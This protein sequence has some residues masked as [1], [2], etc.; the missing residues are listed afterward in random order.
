M[1]KEILTPKQVELLSIVKL[2][3]KDFGLVGGT[4]VAL[5]LGHRR[6]IDLD[7]FSFRGFNN[8]SIKQ[9]IS[10]KGKIDEVKSIKN[11]RIIVVDVVSVDKLSDDQKIVLNPDEKLRG[12]DLKQDG[13]GRFVGQAQ[14][15]ED[16]PFDV[17]LSWPMIVSLV[18]SKRILVVSY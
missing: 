13:K 5:Q 7:L 8:L 16:K 6:S 4:A 18:N 3:S 15:G 2:F 9:K 12:W 1:H 17:Y 11:L 10:R 14:F